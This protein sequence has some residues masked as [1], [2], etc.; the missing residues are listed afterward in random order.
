MMVDSHIHLHEFSAEELTSLCGKSDLIM[1]AV[2]DDY[3]SSMKTLEL[4]ESCSNAVPAIGIHPW[5][6][7]A[8]SWRDGFSRVQALF[9]RVR[10]LGEIGLDKR[11]VPQTFEV[12]VELFNEFLR[13]AEKLGLGVS[14]HGA[15]AW[16]EV[17]DTLTSYRIKAVAIHWYTGPLDLIRN[18]IDN[19][20][21]V[22]INAAALIQR[23][24]REVIKEAPLTSMLTES[25][26]PYNY[27]GL[28]LGPSKLPDL[29]R[30][31]SELKGVPTSEVEETISRNFM[32][33]LKSAGMNV[34]IT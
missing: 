8:D 26:G 11:F 1:L 13:E 32:R 33:F 31:I 34:N 28:R 17:V 24:H 18:I 25:D 4:R 6:V 27:R 29:L 10:F 9:D 12:Q 15:G 30:L 5:K 22:G 21:F 3:A 19:G 7:R 20:Y 16:K 14:V 2:S 23:K